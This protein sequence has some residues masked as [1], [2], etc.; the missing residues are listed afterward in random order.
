[1]DCAPSLERGAPFLVGESELKV[2][3]SH[4]GVSS[5]G[6]G[7][8]FLRGPATIVIQIRIHSG[9]PNSRPPDLLDCDSL[10]PELSTYH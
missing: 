6:G 10:Q 5:G 1:M 9:T 7:G 2:D 8:A 4:L 3:V